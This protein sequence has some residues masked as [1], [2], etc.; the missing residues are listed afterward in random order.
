MKWVKVTR[1]KITR[2]VKQDRGKEM[3]RGGREKRER[4]GREEEKRKRKE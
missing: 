2:I 1:E 4:R 3:G